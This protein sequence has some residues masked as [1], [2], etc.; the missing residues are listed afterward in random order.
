MPDVRR[1][2]H[3]GLGGIVARDVGEGGSGLQEVAVVELP[4][5]HEHPAVLQEGV[6]LFALHH[7]R[8]VRVAT[9]ARLAVG[10]LLYR[11]LLDGFV[12][13]QYGTVEGSTG[14]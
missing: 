9:P 13:L 3:L 10:F 8:L 4:F 5:G 12:A 14:R 2:D 6:V 1:G 7:G 11:M